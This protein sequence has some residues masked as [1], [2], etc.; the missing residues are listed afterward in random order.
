MAEV[1]QVSV[2]VVSYNTVGK[3]RN[4]LSCIEPEHEVIVVDNA[5]ADGSPEMVSS[6]FPHVTLIRNDGNHGFGMANNQGIEAATRPLIL[7]LNSDAYTDP[8]AIARLASVFEDSE[9]VAAGGKLLN[10]DRTLQE[11]CANE[12]T[13]W[14][15][16]C[17]QTYIEKLFTNSR[18]FSPYWMSRRLP[19]GGEVEQVMGACLMMRPLE[20][21]D[22]RYFLYCEDTDLCRRLRQHGRILYAPQAEFVHELG[23]STQDRWIAIVRYNWGKELYFRIHH[24]LWKASMCFILN[25]FGALLRLVAW[26]IPAVLTLFTVGRFRRQIATFGKVLLSP[27]MPV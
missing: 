13:L 6:E 3:L 18:L 8:G 1:S 25:R 4:C 17:E 26:L 10:P 11:S 5:S 27:M 23:S 16:F 14:A 24:G 9:V 22:E 20:R 12:L 21:F 7:C 15:V 19:E 2:V